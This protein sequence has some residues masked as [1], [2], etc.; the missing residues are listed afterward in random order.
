MI[1]GA[2]AILREC[3]GSRYRL[4][5]QVSRTVHAVQGPEGPLLLK[6]HDERILAQREALNQLYE[7]VIRAGFS[8]EILHDRDGQLLGERNGIIYSLHT[9]FEGTSALPPPELL[10]K[11]LADLHT[12]LATECSELGLANHFEANPRVLAERA[13][14]LGKEQAAS[15]MREATDRLATDPASPIHG[16]MHPNNVL[17]DGHRLLFIDFDSTTIL[18]PAAETVFAGRLFFPETNSRRSF[19]RSYE[20]ASG[21][22]IDERQECVWAALH[23]LQRIDYIL[24]AAKHGDERWMYDLDKQMARLDEVLAKTR[25]AAR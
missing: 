18:P 15:L 6:L 16:D 1:K 2:A 10:A 7:T 8:P 4:W 17:F 3:Y 11:R 12:L 23:A 21:K 13:A 19:Y 5:E 9:H 24:A 14:H 25:G 22:G 20:A